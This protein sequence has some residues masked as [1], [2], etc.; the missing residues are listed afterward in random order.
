MPE[1]PEIKII[2]DW[3]SKNFSGTKI[4]NNSKYPQINGFFIQ[5]VKCKGK[6]IFFHL[7]N[8]DHKYYLNSRLALEGK[9]TLTVE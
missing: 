4:I 9:W 2:T 3:L 7:V 5:T 8:G 6:Q 1:G